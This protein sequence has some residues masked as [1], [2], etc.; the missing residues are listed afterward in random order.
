M[1]LLQV[2]QKYA[3]SI[4]LKATIAKEL[5]HYDILESLYDNPIGKKLV[6]QGGTALR[7]CY[8]ND[9]YSEDLDFCSE[10]ILK[11]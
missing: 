7:L 1:N 4:P 6:F 2:A 10:R 11:I 3:N 9:R 5:L 8:R